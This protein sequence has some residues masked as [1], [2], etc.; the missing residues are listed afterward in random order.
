VFATDA[1]AVLAALG[2]G[3]TIGDRFRCDDCAIGITIAY[4]RSEIPTLSGESV[5]CPRCG[6]DLGWLH[7]RK[8]GSA[9]ELV[10]S[11]P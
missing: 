2:F 3:E 10:S 1:D 9:S 7:D 11:N 5:C 4:D 8:R 6:A